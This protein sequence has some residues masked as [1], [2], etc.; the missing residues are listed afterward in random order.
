MDILTVDPYHKKLSWGL[1]LNDIKNCSEDKTANENFKI[2][3]KSMSQSDSQFTLFFYYYWPH[4]TCD[5][6][7]VVGQFVIF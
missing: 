4:L 2:T 5:L 6:T 3:N 7:C 1:A